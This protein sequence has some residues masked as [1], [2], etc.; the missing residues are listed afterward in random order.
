MFYKLRR[1]LL[2]HLIK[3]D[4]KLN[5]SNQFAKTVC[6]V[7][8]A[9]LTISICILPMDKFPL[10]NGEIPGHRNQYELMAEN[11]LA[12]RI[13]FE[14]GDEDQ[15]SQLKNPY[16]PAER[17]ASGVKYHWDHAFYNGTYYMYFGVVPVLLLFLPY[18]ILTG[19]AL[20]TF[21]ATQVFAALIVAGMFA[22][23]HLLSKLFFKKL[24]YSA[25]LALSV[26][27]S[28][29]SVWYSSAEPA[30]YCTAITAAIAL[31]VWS[32]FFFVKAVWG[33]QRE[34]RQLVYAA[35]GAL[36]GALVFGCRPPIALANI[37]VIPMLAV[38][39]R[40][41]KFTAVLFGKLVLAALSYA[42]VAAALMLYNY[43][44]FDNPFEFGQ[45]YQITV[46]DQSQYGFS[47]DASTVARIFR[48]TATH[49]FGYSKPS[50]QFPYLNFSGAFLNFPILMLIAGALRPAAIR[51]LRQKRL[52]GLMIGLLLT[53]LVIT[54]MDIMWSPYLLERYRM[55]IYFL[56]GIA[57]FISIGLWYNISSPTLQKWL[58]AVLVIFAVITVLSC[59][60][61]FMRTT[62]VYYPD[63]VRKIGQI[64]MTWFGK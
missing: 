56:L 45:A 43:A 8:V 23:F 24:H 21:H 11:I 13:H 7:L 16:D 49:L 57:C 42:V 5:Q 51:E 14:Y 6:T 29:M 33:E 37:L 63:T 4:P 31:E 3:P 44:R 2:A 61:Y 22:L 59:F 32:L 38:F 30:L 64:I 60:L 17:K 28:V 41:H 1:C 25:Y 39:I 18:R 47:L 53:V 35:I 54:A 52:S 46:A 26:S 58:N 40:Q 27:F 50:H 10:W 48:D 62:S 36:L 12:G 34:N 9:L 19:T 20:T 55:D 15:L